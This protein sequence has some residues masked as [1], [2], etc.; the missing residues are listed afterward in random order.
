ML[1]APYGGS[2][3]NLQVNNQLRHELLTKATHLPSVQL[4]QRSMHDLELMATGAF[5]PLTRFMS[6]KDYH[7]VMDTM[8]LANG[9]VFPIPIMLPIDNQSSVSEGDEIVLRSPRNE[10]MATMRVEE[11]F[12]RQQKKESESI[13]GTTDSFHPYVAELHT[14]GQRYVSGPMHV[15]NL[16]TYYDFK[17]LR[18]SPS[19][20]R[21][22]LMSYGNSAVVAFQTRNPMHRAH[23]AVVKN[24]AERVGGT[25]LIHPV[26]GITKPGD[27]AYH[28]RVRIYKKLHERY[29]DSDKTVL[30]LLPLAMRMAGPREALLHAIIRKNYGASHFIVGRD[31]ASP[32]RDSKGKPYYSPYEAQTLTTT[33]SKEIGIDIVTFQEMVYVPKQKEYVEVDAVDKRHRIYSLSGT[34]VRQNYLAK[35]KKLPNWFTRPEVG[36]LLSEAYKPMHKKGACIWLTGLPS[37][38]KSTTA[39]VL[40]VLI[41]ETGRNVTLL[42]GDVVRTYLSKGLGFTR[43]DREAN[44]LRMGY[45]ASEIVKHDG[46]VIVAAISPYTDVRSRVRAMMPHGSFVLVFV[47]T[48]LSTCEERDH[49]GMY[50]KARKGKLKQFT[51][52]DDVYELPTDQEVTIRPAQQPPELCA[53]QILDFLKTKGFVL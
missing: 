41:H 32:G 13:C 3:V 5:S 7:S 50:A 22:L 25:L 17:D 9:I 45:V 10:I 21:A 37:A 31:H 48:P 2:L 14:I 19:E 8:R 27:V 28:L 1:N 4:S 44:V 29:F 51:G 23:E 20:L 26:V 35:G 39:S 24:A 38:G 43:E 53:K 6:E 12:E 11:I 49:K 34:Q 33:Y 52:V 46:I 18:R 30:S 42:D 47:D 16:P 36:H 40:E 15:L